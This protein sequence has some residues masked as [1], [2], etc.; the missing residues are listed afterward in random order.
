MDLNLTGRR[1]V[2]TGASRGIGAAIARVLADEGCSLDLVARDAPT[3]RSLAEEISTGYGVAARVHTV[4][5]RDPD[6]VAALAEQV[7]SIDI[8]VN[9]AGDIPG[10]PLD[11][12]DDHAWR[13]AFDLKVLGYI[14]LTRHIYAGMKQ[15]GGGVIVN[16][17]GASAERFDATYIAGC[18]GNAALTAFT[19]TLGGASLL[20]GIRVVGVSPGPVDTER[21]VALLRSFAE[22]RLGDADRYAELTAR[23]PRGRAATPREIA[24]T[25]AFLASDRSAYTSG[26][27]LTVDG[28]MTAAS[29]V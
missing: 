5:L 14:G 8:L 12:L 15:R 13:H 3:L 22:A 26:A 23:F 2:V 17:I 4:D 7:G 9:N 6:A 19:R 20:D 1:A 29:S 21:I 28:G 10:G 18:T 11:T 25:V 16:N 24:D 27:V